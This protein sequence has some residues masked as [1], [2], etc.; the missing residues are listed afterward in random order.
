MI[1]IAGSAVDGLK[2]QLGPLMFTNWSSLLIPPAGSYS[3]THSIEVTTTG[4]IVGMKN[5]VRK[6]AR[7]PSNLVPKN[8][9]H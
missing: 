4:V 2:S 3:H 7:P 1:M 5:T 8:R 9:Q 6:S